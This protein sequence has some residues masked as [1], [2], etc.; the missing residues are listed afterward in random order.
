M[1]WTR[2]ID[3]YCERTDPGYWAEPVNAITNLGFV[4]VAVVMWRRSGGDRL[5]RALCGLLGLIGIGS[6]LFHTH[7]QVWAAIADTTPIALFILLWTYAANRR[8]W[9]LSRAGAVVLAALFVPYVIVTV[10]VFNRLPL[11]EVSAGYWPVPVMIAIYAVL[12]RGR[13][14]EVARGM[15]IGGAILV[16]SLGFRTADMIVCSVLPLG[17]HFVWHV[18]NA[19]ML[20]WMIEVVGRHHRAVRA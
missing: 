18:M 3:G 5:A 14:P 16:V 1:E 15:A 10:P 19:I 11:L 13:L 8:F 20:G 12:L 6:Y 7:A 4:V 2:V 9:G 17:T